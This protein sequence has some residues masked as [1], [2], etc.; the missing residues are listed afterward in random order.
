[1]NI[2]NIRLS[3]A[4]TEI[5]KNKLYTR[6]QEAWKN[7]LSAKVKIEPLPYYVSQ[8][9]I[10]GVKELGMELLLLPNWICGKIV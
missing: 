2:E 5:P 6:E 10:A 3:D 7:A 4:Q 9:I 1:M 8:E